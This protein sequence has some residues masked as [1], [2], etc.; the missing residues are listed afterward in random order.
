MKN[1]KEVYP[2]ALAL[3]RNGNWWDGAYDYTPL[4]NSFGYD[5]IIRVDVKDYQGDS[6]LLFKN[7]KKLGYLIF[8]WGSCSGCD[9]LQACKS[10]KAIEELREKLHNSIKWFNN[11]KDMLDYFQNKDW[12]DEFFWYVDEG[13]EFVRKVIE[14]LKKEILRNREYI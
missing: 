12:E 2:E 5:I 9:A 8:G 13:K 11:A 10:Y 3:G 14:Y 6:Y 1:I 4:L 7:G